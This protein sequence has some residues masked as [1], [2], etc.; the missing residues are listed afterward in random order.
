MAES[1]ATVH[2]YNDIVF[3]LPSWREIY[4]TDSER[5]MAFEAAEAFGERVR[6]IYERL[7]YTLVVV[8]RGPVRARAR[9]IVETLHLGVDAHEADPAG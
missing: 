8:P 4:V 1:A 6:H 2:R 7:D 3:A 9:F 5:T